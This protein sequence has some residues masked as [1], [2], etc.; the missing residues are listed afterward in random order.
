VKI[1]VHRGAK[2]K[3]R[4]LGARR[5]VDLALA[6]KRIVE[7]V[8]GR[9]RVELTPRW[10]NGL[11]VLE[12]RQRIRRLSTGVRGLDE[13]LGGG[14]EE[15]YVTE[16][17]GE[18]GAGKTQLCHQLAVM[19]QLPREEGG[20]GARALYIDTE[21]TFRPE[22]VISI[23]RY[24]G[25]DPEEA[26]ENIV[27]VEAGEE[28]VLVEAIL[29]LEKLEVGLVEIDSIA[30]PYISPRSI[31]EARRN[32]GR[33]TSILKLLSQWGGIAVITNVERGDRSFGDPYTSMWVDT[34]VMLRP[35]GGG[36]VEAKVVMPR[37]PLSTRMRICEEGL[38]DLEVEE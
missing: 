14:L 26:L 22:R 12:R 30:F 3:L 29:G 5:A 18:F 24:R 8:A 2:A 25:L 23:A 34:R 15:G 37:S 28:D 19:V 21:G 31:R 1:Y 11:K 20:L 4:R 9:I 35:L 27:Y 32:W 13:L 6:D 38:L 16:L 10:S 7:L 33:L 36:V 17:V